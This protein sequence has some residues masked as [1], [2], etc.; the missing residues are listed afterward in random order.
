MEIDICS[1]CGFIGSLDNFTQTKT[2][3]RCKN[4]YLK[5]YFSNNEVK[6][7]RKETRKEYLLRNKEKIAKHMAEYYIKNKKHINAKNAEY[8]KKNRKRINEQHRDYQRGRQRGRQKTFNQQILKYQ[9]I[10]KDIQFDKADILFYKTKILKIQT[11]INKINQI[12]LIRKEKRK[13]IINKKTQ[14]DIKYYERNKQRIENRNKK[15]SKNL[16][17]VYIRSQ[18][19][20]AG[21]GTKDITQKMIKTKRAQL[22]LCRELKQIKRNIKNGITATGNQ[23]TQ[24]T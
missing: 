10:L 15:A 17:D 21:I 9:S 19:T 24:T 18:L 1:K 20:H 2:C 16:E 6:G 11:K 22:S 23:G 8:I 14:Y 13:L 7:K 5:Q 3:R 4:K 12:K